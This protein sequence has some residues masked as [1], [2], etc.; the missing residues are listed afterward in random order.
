MFYKYL[1]PER[2]DVLQHLSIR[3]SPLESL[4]DP[5]ECRPLLDL[6][7]YKRVLVSDVERGAEELW[8]RAE[9]NERTAENW[10]ILERERLNLLADI[11]HKLAPNACGQ[12]L[13]EDLSDRVRILSLSRTQK[14]LLMWTHYAQQ[15]EGFVIGFDD[16]HPFFYQ[17]DRSGRKTKP[18]SVSYSSNRSSINPDGDRRVLYERLLTEKAL[19]WAY[20]EEVRIMRA[21]VPDEVAVTVDG[22]GYG[23]IL[24]PLPKEMIKTVLFGYRAKQSLIDSVVEAIVK[25]GIDCRVYRAKVCSSEYRLQF[26]ELRCS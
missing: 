21:A 1:P 10:Q 25:N 22:Y 5:F 13:M 15:G 17:S 8:D 18:F 20:E 14:S 2:M 6:D 23:V 16:E 3:F 7:A 26:E 4:N 24:T 19:E 11:D 9:Q 12:I